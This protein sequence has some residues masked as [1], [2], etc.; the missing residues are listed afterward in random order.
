MLKRL[1]TFLSGGEANEPSEEELSDKSNELQLCLAADEELAS[2]ELGG[3]RDSI[4]CATR[5]RFLLANDMDVSRSAVSLRRH[6]MW[7]REMFPIEMTPAVREILDS[8]RFRFLGLNRQGCAVSVIDFM[9]GK[10]LDGVDDLQ[11]FQN[12]Y[13]HFVEGVLSHMEEHAPAGQRK[14]VNIIVGG[15]PPTSFI[16]PLSAVMEANYPERLASSIIY[17]VPWAFKFVVDSMIWF[18]PSRTQKKF[19]VCSNEDQLRSLAEVPEQSEFQLP[20]DLLGGLAGVRERFVAEG[21]NIGT[22]MKAAASSLDEETTERLGKQGID[23]AKL[24]QVP[25][26]SSL[27]GS[28]QPESTSSS[29]SSQDQPP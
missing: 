19:A 6:C 11:D 3:I 4:T 15:P 13:I 17:P 25:L 16:R 18:L 9:W 8:N 22:I 10:F 12:A 5:R 1:S 7:K 20:D 23:I 21:N 26:L 29:A 2:E 27:V 24:E 14:L 28:Q